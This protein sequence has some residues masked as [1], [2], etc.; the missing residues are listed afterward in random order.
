MPIWLKCIDW[1]K[2]KKE[3]LSRLP[4]FL[5]IRS[6]KADAQKSSLKKVASATFL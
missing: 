5:H 2:N 4:E 3:K 1:R 6:E